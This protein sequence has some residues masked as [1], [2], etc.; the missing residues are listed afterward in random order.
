MN[1]LWIPFV[2]S[3]EIDANDHENSESI[4][5]IALTESYTRC[6]NLFSSITIDPNHRL[7]ACCGITSKYIE[8]LDL[9]DVRQFSIKE[10]YNRQFNDFMKVWLATEG[11][12][13]IMDFIAGYTDINEIYKTEHACQVCEKIFGNPQYLQILR[14][15]HR[16]M[17]SN[18][19]LKYFIN[20]NEKEN[21]KA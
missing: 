7:L 8:Y 1:G 13:R 12:H 16:K 19:L 9:G 15:N 3:E 5:K 14:E 18:I 2:Q 11:A 10:L 20:K 21:E 4:K 6:K 17:Y